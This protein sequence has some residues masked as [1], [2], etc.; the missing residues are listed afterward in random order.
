MDESTWTT[1]P[2]EIPTDADRRTICAIL[3]ASGLEVR[4]VK[5][6]DSPRS[7]PKRYIQ[8]RA[9]PEIFTLTGG[10]NPQ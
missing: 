4:I 9:G 5:A 1:I 8:F 3:A 6:K 10:K 2:K 7:S